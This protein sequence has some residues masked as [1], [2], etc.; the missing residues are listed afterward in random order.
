MSKKI[1]TLIQFIDLTPNVNHFCKLDQ[2]NMSYSKRHL[3]CLTSKAIEC[4]KCTFEGSN[5]NKEIA[6]KSLKLNNT[7]T[8]T[9]S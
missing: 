3:S 5:H 2:I 8:E 9:K 1:D 6:L 4:V 7:T